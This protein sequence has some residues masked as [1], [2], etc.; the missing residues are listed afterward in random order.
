MSLHPTL[1]H[2]RAD[3]PR[4]DIW[5]R[6]FGAE[7]VPLK[8]MI[9]QRHVVPAG[10]GRTEAVREVYFLDLA[11]LDEAQFERLVEHISETFALPPAEI[12]AA[13]WTEGVPVLIE[14]VS[15]SFDAHVL[16]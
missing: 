7:T 11:A 2:I 15:V 1:G 12:C 10:H 3:S 5:R 6:I 13:I 9:P 16:L 4:A 8:S 14:D